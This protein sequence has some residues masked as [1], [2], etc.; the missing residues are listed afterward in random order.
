[1]RLDKVARKAGPETSRK[2]AKIPYQSASLDDVRKA[3]K[4]LGK[5]TCEQ[6]IHHLIEKTK[7]GFKLREDPVSGMFNSLCL[8]G[9]IVPTGEEG[10][11]TSGASAIIWRLANREERRFLRLYIGPDHKT[12]WPSA[13]TLMEYNEV[14]EFLRKHPNNKVRKSYKDYR[15][16]L[17]FRTVLKDKGIVWFMENYD[18]NGAKV[19]KE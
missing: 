13:D 15:K 19:R 3:L 6:V 16:G 1:M 14:R 18:T 5:A 12:P 10:V 4:H 9:L 8:N 2:A 7:P 17:L 11:N